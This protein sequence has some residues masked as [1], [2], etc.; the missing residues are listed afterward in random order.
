MA[1]QSNRSEIDE[2]ETPYRVA[3]AGYGSTIWL[4]RKEVEL[5]NLLDIE[6]Y[7][8]QHGDMNC[9]TPEICGWFITRRD[10]DKIK[11]VEGVAK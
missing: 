10:Y 4:S 2:R 6:C 11:R 9:P 3:R 8:T 7:P 1:T 5:V